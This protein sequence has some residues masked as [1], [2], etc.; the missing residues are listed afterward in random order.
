ML[1]SLLGKIEQEKRSST[2]VELIFL[3]ATHTH[4]HHGSEKVL[5][6]TKHQAMQIKITSAVRMIVI[7]KTKNKY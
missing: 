2:A 5:N 4:C 3:K 7:K 6:I 1:L